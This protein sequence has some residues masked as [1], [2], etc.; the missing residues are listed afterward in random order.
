VLIERIVGRQ[1]ISK[2]LI[3]GFGSV[4]EDTMD[5]SS[6]PCFLQPYISDRDKAEMT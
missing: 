6:T 4:T 1:E 2:W 3:V 5:S